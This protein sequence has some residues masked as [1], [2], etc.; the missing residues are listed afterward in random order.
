MKQIDTDELCSVIERI[1]KCLSQAQLPYHITGD[2][3]S[4]YYGEPRYTQ[5]IDI[6]LTI[7][8]SEDI[9]SL[10]ELL[11]PEFIFDE[12]AARNAI[13]EK[14]MFQLLDD[15]TMIRVD[16][17]VGE[18]VP[19]ELKRS[20]DV[21]L[22]P[23]LRANLVSCED[24][25]LSKLLWIKKGSGKSEQDVIMMI[26]SASELDVNFVKSMSESLGVS[27]ILENLI[28]SKE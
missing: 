25:I 5:D 19:Q 22:L 11:S 15:A 26:K 16:I 27:E 8:S 4:S 10:F 18:S 1:V 12:V 13:S 14:S 3:A 2:L 28:S 24:A 21:E 9:K 23:G 7:Q 17:H 6:V 20:K